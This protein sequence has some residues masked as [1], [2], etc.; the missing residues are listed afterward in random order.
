M[1]LGYSVSNST[2]FPGLRYTGRIVTDPLGTMPQGEGTIVDGGGSQT[3]SQRWGDYSSMNIDPVNDCTF[4]YTT[5]Y[6]PATSSSG[7]NTRIGSATFPGCESPVIANFSV[8]G[9]VTDP[10]GRG[11]TGVRIRIA[12][13]G[14]GQAY[15][16]QTTVNGNYTVQ[17]LPE[18]QTYIVTVIARRYSFSS[19]MVMISGS[20]ATGIN[21]MAIE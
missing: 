3:G 5:E 9:R 21:F 16:A 14:G 12:P 18:G 19:Q 6:Y 8:S 7:W 20:N 10:A 13:T 11:L 1:M 15:F 17:G 4:W 2:V